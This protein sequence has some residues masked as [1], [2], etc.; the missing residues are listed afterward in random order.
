[1]NK[2]MLFGFGLIVLGVVLFVII[3][4]F[5]KVKELTDTNKASEVLESSKTGND[6]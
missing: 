2:K 3:K 1:M 6:K 4:P 5:S